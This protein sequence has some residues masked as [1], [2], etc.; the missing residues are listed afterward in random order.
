MWSIWPTK[1]LIVQC[2]VA[3]K[4]FYD[5]SPDGK[6]RLWPG[7]AEA[8]PRAHKQP[9]AEEVRRRLMYA[10]SVEAARC[11]SEGIVN[12]ADADVGSLLGWGFPPFLGGV[13][14]QIDTVGSAHFVMECDQLAQNYGARFNV[15]AALREIADRSGRYHA[16]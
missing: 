15:P 6:K 4:G 3:G 9:D 12:A 14:S 16:V 1:L 2:R 11:V 7:L 13:I 5:Y 10:Q 8:F